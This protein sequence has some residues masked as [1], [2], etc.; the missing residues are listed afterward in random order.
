MLLSKQDKLRKL[1]DYT[2]LDYKT[3][4]SKYA[5]AAEYIKEISEANNIYLT[6]VYD[7]LMDS[8]FAD[9]CNYESLKTIYSLT[10]ILATELINRGYSTEYISQELRI[11][12]LNNRIV[13]DGNKQEVIDF[14]IDFLFALKVNNVLLLIPENSLKGFMQLW[15]YL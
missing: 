12:F 15:A 4:I 13:I 8:I 3:K 1:V 14:L 11:S 6:T 9:E 5:E 2:K 7:L 10:R